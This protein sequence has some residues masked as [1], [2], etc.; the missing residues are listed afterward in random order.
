MSRAKIAR[1]PPKERERRWQQHQASTRGQNIHQ[2]RGYSPNIV[3]RRKKTVKGVVAQRMLSRCAQHYALAL[4]APFSYKGVACIPDLHGVPSKKLRVKTRGIFSTGVDGNGFLIVD[5]WANSSDTSAITA[6]SASLV[7]SSAPLPAFSVGVIDALQTKLPYSATDFATSG[8]DPAV[9]ARTVAVGVRIRYLGTELARSGQITAVR[10]PD[11]S[12]LINIPYSQMKSFSTAKTY[13][14]GRQWIY[15]MYRPVKPR[16][17]EFSPNYSTASNGDP[18]GPTKEMGFAIEGTSTPSGALGPA[19]FEFEMV[20]YVEYVG[21]IDNITAT[22]VDIQGMSHVRNSMPTKSSTD[23]PHQRF[24]KVVKHIED[25]IGESIPA[26]AAGAL[27]YKSI[28]A[29][30]AEAAEGESLFSTLAGYLP[31]FSSLAEGVLPAVEE[32]APLA[33]TLL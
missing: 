21:N 2:E 11:N 6:S 16:E 13:T 19:P 22:H 10:H 20:R 23:K 27:G 3:L 4:E 28:V 8:T 24:A 1:L 9:E 25:S 33:L 29:P 32:A 12:S 26:A 15:L 14:N 7:S 30:A 18:P 5:C 31:D 17:Y